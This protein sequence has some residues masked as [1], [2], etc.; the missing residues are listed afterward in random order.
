M[1]KRR[2][3]PCSSWGLAACFAFLLCELLSWSTELQTS[4]LR[5]V[6]LSSKG[7]RL[8][9][10]RVHLLQDRFIFHSLLTTKT[11]SDGEFHFSSVPSGEYVL[12][13]GPHLE[14]KR[15]FVGPKD[16][17]FVRCKIESSEM[18]FSGHVSF[19]GKPIDNHRM[20]F[21]PLSYSPGRVVYPPPIQSSEIENGVYNLD[22]LLPGKYLIRITKSV[23]SAD[24]PRSKN[25]I[26]VQFSSIVSIQKK[27]SRL[28]IQ[29]P[30]NTL[31]GSLSNCETQPPFNLHVLL[32]PAD[33]EPW[34]L[35][36]QMSNA[37]VVDGSGQF[38][39]RNLQTGRY[40][41]VLTS[42]RTRS[43]GFNT[44]VQL[45]SNISIT[46]GNNRLKWQLEIPARVDL[47]LVSTQNLRLKPAFSFSRL[48]TLRFLVC[49]HMHLGPTLLKNLHQCR[50]GCCKENTKSM[51][52]LLCIT[53]RTIMLSETRQLKCH[54]IPNR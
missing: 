6:V 32:V 22:S 4:D 48:I 53:N 19:S 16:E 29:V 31:S 33:L 14:G 40:D 27:Q 25:Q 1:T 2:I 50:F 35:P 43:E 37:A 13:F 39:F 3:M 42:T 21:I 18:K 23:V 11:D 24:K 36:Y 17:V 20:L 10:S 26:D 7:H 41:L 12:A 15:I 30:D 28:D 38:V 5:G 54:R 47:T 8:Q 9:D 52:C 46:E 34:S 45:K 51:L 44:G 49:A